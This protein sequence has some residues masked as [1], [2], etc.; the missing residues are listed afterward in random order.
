M[1]SALDFTIK[2]KID[3]LLFRRWSLEVDKV[4]INTRVENAMFKI[5][6]NAV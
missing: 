6:Y 2:R 4:K 5:V 1:L 3:H